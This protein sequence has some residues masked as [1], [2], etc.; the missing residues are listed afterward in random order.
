LVDLILLGAIAASV[1]GGWRS[2]FIRRLAGIVFLVVAFVLGAQL[3]VPAGAL[4]S[5][6]FPVIPEQY[7]DAMG[8]SVVFSALLVGFNLFSRVIL[9]RIAV[10]GVSRSTDQ[11]FGAVLG[12]VESI[13]IISVAI[14]ILHTYTDPTN[15]LSALTDLG[16]LHDVRTAVDESTI[17][18]LLSKTTVP[19]VLTILGPLLPTD[20][21]SIVPLAIPGGVPGFPIPIPGLSI[22]S[23][24]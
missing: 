11:V 18:Q 4:I 24:R 1:F 8:Y 19:I 10:R 6:F 9:S 5:G 16:G 20:I 17:G 7:A 21:K 3:R 12:G 22:P 23:V 13:L 2:G 15:S 14:V